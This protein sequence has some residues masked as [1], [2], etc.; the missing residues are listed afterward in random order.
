MVSYQAI[1]LDD[2]A[3]WHVALEGMP[4][5]FA[6][7]WDHCQAIARSSGQVTHLWSAR[8]GE[9]RYA[10]VFA[11]RKYGG[12]V[13]VVTPYGFTGFVGSAP[14]ADLEAAWRRFAVERE[15]V[16]A[17]LVLNPVLSSP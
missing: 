9:G 10:C 16:C 17:Y 7:T 6:H 15:Y 1:P 8:D 4:H 12:L 5:A 11:E 14:S 2:R 3:D 13:D